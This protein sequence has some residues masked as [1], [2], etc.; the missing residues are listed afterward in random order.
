ME[1]H[2][3]DD[4][5]FKTLFDKL[6]PT[7]KKKQGE[8]AQKAML[9]GIDRKSHEP[10]PCKVCSKSYD[11]FDG[12]AQPKKPYCPVCQSSFDAGLICFVTIAGDWAFVEFPGADKNQ[13][14]QLKGKTFTV[15]AER[16]KK[17][18]ASLPT[19]PIEESPENN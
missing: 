4:A 15:D 9:D 1:G 2:L 12:F 5:F 14:N 10:M 16:M 11:G 19:P 6:L 7:F 8:L 17:I 13:I 3:N 18:K